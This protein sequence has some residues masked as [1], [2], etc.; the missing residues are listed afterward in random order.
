MDP[1]GSLWAYGHI[2]ST[3]EP[4]ATPLASLLEAVPL[5]PEASE[6]AVLL[7]RRRSSFEAVARRTASS[8]GCVK[9]L[10]QAWYRG[11]RWRGEKRVASFGKNWGNIGT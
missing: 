5:P 6:R 1:N 3:P 4:H 9:R 8:D 7:E 2:P 11:T 10:K